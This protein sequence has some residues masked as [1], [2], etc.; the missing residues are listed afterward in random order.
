MSLQDEALEVN[1][2]TRRF[3]REELYAV[4][5]SKPISKLAKELGISD[6]AIAKAC[7]RA[8]IPSPGVGYWAKVQHGKKVKRTPLPPPTL[9]TPD[10][11]QISP[12][13]SNA[14]RALAP[15]AQEKIANESSEELRIAVPKTLSNLHPLLRP[16]R[17]GDRTHERS[18]PP[19]G[20]LHRPPSRD[21]KV[22]R[23]RLRILSALFRALEK[24]GQKIFANPQNPLDIDLVIDGERIE[25]SLS[26]RQ[27]QVKEDLTPE[28][29]EKP[30]NAAFGV[31][32]RMTLQPTGALIFKIQTWIGTGVRTQWRDGS[33]GPL[34]KRLNEI[35]AGLL[36]A[37]G[38]LHQQ[39][40]ER[41]E[42]Q[43]RLLTERIEREK[44]EEAHRKVARRIQALLQQV[45]RWLQAADVRAYVDAVH[46]AA[47]RGRAKIDRE[48]LKTWASWALAR[49]DQMDPIV[50][51]DPLTESED[52]ILG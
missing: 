30:W 6:V 46:T 3:M 1:I 31:K 12:G 5:W 41:E 47:R 44:R 8:D 24:R 37:A 49:A 23:R 40:L 38:T 52:E 26:E 7:R 11:V 4:V 50:V 29:L 45:T 19:Y 32:S 22:E 16:W 34:E 14:L 17:G 25:F 27:K 28:E 33:R 10:V 36:A 51:G 15:E 13:L 20:Y 21:A 43:R 48:R 39:R 2:V 18:S 9:K 35:V 42:E